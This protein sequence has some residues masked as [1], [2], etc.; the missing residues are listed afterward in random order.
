MP[1]I[2]LRLAYSKTVVYLESSHWPN[3]SH[4]IRAEI[5]N[6]CVSVMNRLLFQK[7]GA[8]FMY[9]IRVSIFELAMWRISLLHLLLVELCPRI[10]V[11]FVCRP[12]RPLGD[13]LIVV[14]LFVYL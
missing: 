11:F 5:K 10:H 13:F 12:N 1:H 7:F 2:Q 9:H 6:I 4:S 14:V 8:D 3:A